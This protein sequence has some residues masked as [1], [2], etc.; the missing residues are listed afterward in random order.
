MQRGTSQ[1]QGKAGS[2]VQLKLW[3]L[4][5][6][7]YTPLPYEIHIYLLYEGTS[8]LPLVCI[9]ISCYRAPGPFQHMPRLNQWV[10]VVSRIS[11]HCQASW[12]RRYLQDPDR[13][14]CP[15]SC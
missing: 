11:R 15:M 13:V 7:L 6:I 14:C 5:F 9:C 2:R 3:G 12:D 1:T 10:F 8:V 4:P